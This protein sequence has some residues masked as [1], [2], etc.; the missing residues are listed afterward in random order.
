[1]CIAIN[2]KP[3]PYPS[4]QQPSAQLIDQSLANMDAIN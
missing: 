4:Q 1:M 2:I 3:K